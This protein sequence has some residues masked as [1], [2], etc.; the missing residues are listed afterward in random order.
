LTTIP[1]KKVKYLSFALVLFVFSCNQSPK[2]EKA[3]VSAPTVS[4]KIV[5]KE[6]G[7]CDTLTNNGVAVVIDL[8][9]PSDLG[10]ASEKIRT[11]LTDKVIERINS[12][13][14]SVSL[15]KKPEA[16]KSAEAAYDVFAF[17]YNS[18]KKDFPE[19]PGCWEIEL[20]GDTVMVS[21][22]LMT[23]QFDHYAFTGGA[24][25]N[26]FRSYHVFD[27]ETGEETDAKTFV[28]DSVALLKKVELAFRK[29]EKLDKNADLEEAGYFL[30]DHKFFVPANY[31]FT[32]K[33]VFFYYNPY[34]I[35]AYVR[36][37]IEFTI[38]YSEL[39]GIVRKDMIF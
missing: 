9:E 29:E 15:A 14:D 1:Y 26:S 35:A 6:F 12:H 38:P 11:I 21:E 18:F 25:P 19:A 13:A 17:N 33:G 10:K 34:E 22:K 7:H 36:G 20:K 32:R 2:K 5:H 30:L 8:W 24:H 4:G 23:Y 27:Q 3:A 39:E 31:T 28:A 37:S 16:G